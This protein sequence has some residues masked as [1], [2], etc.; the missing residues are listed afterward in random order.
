M[1]MILVDPRCSQVATKIGHHIVH[2]SHQGTREIRLTL[3]SRLCRQVEHRVPANDSAPQSLSVPQWFN[4]SAFSLTPH[5][6]SH[7]LYLRPFVY[8]TSGS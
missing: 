4:S 1:G 5:F 6:C 3:P 7:L 2:K 8:L